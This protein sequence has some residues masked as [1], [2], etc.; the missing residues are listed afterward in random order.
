MNRRS[1]ESEEEK[2]TKKKAGKALSPKAK[3]KRKADSETGS[4]FSPG[5]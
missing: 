5:Q 3:S 2:K 4:K 1:T